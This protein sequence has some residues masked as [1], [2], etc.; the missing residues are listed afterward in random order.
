LQKGRRWLFTFLDRDGIPA[1]NH[2][3]ERALRPAVI[4]RK[5]ACGHKTRRGKQTRQILASLTAACPQTGRGFVDS[6]RPY[7]IL[8][9]A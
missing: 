9:P 6:L 7:L 3:A 2:A 4:A 5:P 8:K 1:D